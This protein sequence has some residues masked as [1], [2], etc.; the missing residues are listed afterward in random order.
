MR[1]ISRDPIEEEG[2]LNLYAYVGNNAINAIDSLGLVDDKFVPD[3]SKHGGP[4]ADWYRNGKNM[5]RYRPDG[6]GIPFKGKCPPKVPKSLLPNLLKAL[7]KL[8]LIFMIQIEYMNN[9]LNNFYNYDPRDP[10]NM[11]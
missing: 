11:A 3:V 2:G 5:G 6:S 9:E 4:H 10:D 8:N 1:C 7:E